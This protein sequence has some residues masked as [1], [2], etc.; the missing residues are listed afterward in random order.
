MKL[1]ATLS[2]CAVLWGASLEVR[3]Q[4][5]APPAPRSAPLTLGGW[6]LKTRASALLAA[7]GQ[8]AALVS[9]TG[10]KTA[11]ANSIQKVPVIASGALPDWAKAVVPA[12]DAHQVVWLYR[13]QNHVM[14]FVVNGQGLVDVVGEVG[15]PEPPRRHYLEPGA[16]GPPATQ[17]KFS[18]KLFNLGDD[19][20][21]IALIG[22]PDA[23]R[24]LSATTAVL[25]YK[26]VDF[27]VRNNRVV[28]I[29]IR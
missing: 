10:A 4:T 29:I 3:A 22:Q 2:L 16:S 11:R 9:N 15:V 8:P 24:S 19:A 23:V 7:L 5:L 6:A 25:S 28:R 26:D 14:T 12:L 13:R 27:T 17:L 1:V 21:K 18:N 20:R